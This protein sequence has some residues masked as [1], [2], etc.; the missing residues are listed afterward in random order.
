MLFLFS[1]QLHAQTGVIAG[2]LID[3][4]TAEPLIG[5]AIYLESNP[6]LGTSTDL[7]GRYRLSGVPEGT[8]S[9]VIRY[10]SYQ[11]KTVE[12]IAVKAGNTVQLDA[13]LSPAT[14]LLAEV[15]IRESF[16]AESVAAVYTM[17][18]KAIAVQDGISR[19]IIA[20]S[21]D[22]NT[23][24]VLKRLPGTTI[25]DN[26]FAV[27]R[28]LSDRYNNAMVNGLLLP[29]TEPDRKAFA[30]DLYP[31]ALLDYLIITKTA[32]PDL[33]AEFAGGIIQ[34]AT[35]D[36]PDENFLDINLGTGMDTRTTFKPFTAYEGGGTDWLGSD[37]GSRALPS[38]FPESPNEVR[39]S[40][41]EELAEYARALPRN[42]G[43][44]NSGNGML[45]RSGQLSGGI[46]KDFGAD[47]RFGAIF[48]LTYN[49][50]NT[51]RDANELNYLGVSADSAFNY[52]D[53]YYQENIQTGAMLNLGVSL[54]GRH[55]INWRNDYSINSSDRVIQREGN[56]F[57]NTIPERRTYYEFVS[58]RNLNSSLN[59]DHSLLDNKVRVDWTVGTN[60]T[61]RDQPDSRFGRYTLNQADS[62]YDL[63]VSVAPN[64]TSIGHFFS[65]LEERT[66]SGALNIGVP[67]SL[68]NQSQ[69][70]KVGG[71]YQH[72]E[73]EFDARILG[74]RAIPLFFSDP[75][76]L[77]I[78]SSPLDQVFTDANL[79]PNRLVIDEITN[80]SDRYAGQSDLM[81]AYAM[82]D[83]RIGT[84]LRI[85]WGARMERFT[86]NIETADKS[87]GGGEAPTRIN[88]DTT[89]TDIFPSINLTYA[90][91][92]KINI[93]LSGS[94]TVARPEFR[95]RALFSYY[96]F[97]N[98]TNVRGN[99]DLLPTTI[100]NADLRFEYYPGG[101]QI[102]SATAFYKYF[103]DP[104]SYL[105][106]PGEGGG[107]IGTDE[108]PINEASARNIGLETEV[109]KNF[110]FV[111]VEQLVFSTNLAYINSVAKLD[112]GLIAA[113]AG[114]LERG[115]FYQ[116]P[117]IVNLGL[118][119][120]DRDGRFDATVLFNTYGSR[121]IRLGN[122]NYPDIFEAPQNRLDA[123]VS[124]RI[125]ENLRMRITG[126]NLLRAPIIQYWDIGEGTPQEPIQNGRYD[127]GVEPLI[128]RIDPG[129]GISVSLTWRIQ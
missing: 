3:E 2:M 12:G 67:F 127:E 37:D 105:R 89:Y 117:W 96:N 56:D 109:R 5:A 125:V 86:Q 120:L 61:V 48:G 92:D 11:T 73:R 113:Q 111:G 58:R 62:S 10:V 39:S 24:E 53:Q 79:Q 13:T 7:D 22:N 94:E 6:S 33:P 41:I 27:V 40:S 129:A 30:F 107:G 20:R 81:A 72:K 99:L 34:L 8:H 46:A 75:E 60:R 102:I 55:K 1:L 103:N 50:N 115:L 93:R 66:Y 43:L 71:Y 91:N 64:F 98:F 69:M 16:R 121:R 59:G 52:F 38:I 122:A 29:S 65:F 4:A 17:Q 31:S 97:Q 112:T 124:F 78:V 25:Q 18:K 51:L 54:K 35:R 57:V 80:E 128:S 49:G 14:E 88:N 82:L 44:D 119:W 32:S 21:P 126:E 118:S 63:A 104:I 70:V 74:Y 45:N 26:K 42:W 23:G 101:G 106:L 9:L 83:N 87:A 77:T 15:V 108:I 68:G 84:K 28:G 123:Q 36:I 116:S 95:E 90:V 19:D 76:Y 114:S 110:D 85:V 47:N 100:Y